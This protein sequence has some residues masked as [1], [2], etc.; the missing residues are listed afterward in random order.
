[1]GSARYST[2]A[3]PPRQSLVHLPGPKLTVLART[4]LPRRM[5]LRVFAPTIWGC[6]V[7]LTG[8][9][10]WEQAT[11]T[12]TPLTSPLTT[13]PSAGA[14]LRRPRVPRGYDTVLHPSYHHCKALYPRV[15]KLRSRDSSLDHR[16]AI[17]MRGTVSQD[18]KPFM[19]HVWTTKDFQCKG[20]P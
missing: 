11:S 16:V 20:V 6:G 19:F 3:K 13:L 4:F 15:E 1:M 7:R 12:S 2:H 8:F 14:P 10:L 17:P 5:Q 18:E 9:F